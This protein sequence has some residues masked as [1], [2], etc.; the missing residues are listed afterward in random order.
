MREAP[1]QLPINPPLH[2]DV[3]TGLLESGL[4]GSSWTVEQV[5]ELR[6]CLWAT[7]TDFTERLG[8]EFTSLRAES[9]WQEDICMATCHR[10]GYQI[11]GS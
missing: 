6:A 5:M 11:L 10:V 4:G 1:L 8:I 7:E 9:Q 2:C 3:D